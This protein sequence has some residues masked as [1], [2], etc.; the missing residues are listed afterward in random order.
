MTWRE[1][2]IARILLILAGMLAEDA[3]LA[4]ELRHLSS[5]IGVNAP[6]PSTGGSVG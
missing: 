1:K 3:T 6:S 5:H 2:T 4:Q